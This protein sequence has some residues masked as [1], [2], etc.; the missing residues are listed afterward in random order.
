MLWGADGQKRCP[1]WLSSKKE[2]PI[3]PYQ[4]RGAFRGQLIL[5]MILDTTRQVTVLVVVVFVVLARF[6]NLKPK[7]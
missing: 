5:D 7:I 1:P 2:Q 4:P 3:L 6:T